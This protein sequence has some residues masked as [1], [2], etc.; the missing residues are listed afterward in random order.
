MAPST[1][2]ADVVPPPAVVVT[3]PPVA[4][5]PAAAEPAN[6]AEPAATAA[7]SKKPLEQGAQ[8]DLAFILDSTGSMGSYIASATQSIVDIVNE[9]VRSER[10][11]VRFGLVAYRDHPPQDSSWITKVFPF[12]S[13]T[14]QMKKNLAELSAAGGGD[15]PEAVTTALHETLNLPWRP[16]GE[17]RANAAMMKSCFLFFFFSFSF[18]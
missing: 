16:N 15:G 3:E 7:S 18:G 8:L 5:E 14:A 11:D 4:N 6:A 13:S 17:H 10:A 1:T 2:P 9:I 12:S